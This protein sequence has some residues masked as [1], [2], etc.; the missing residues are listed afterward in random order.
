MAAATCQK[1]TLS[2]EKSTAFKCFLVAV[3][4]NFLKVQ[5]WF[6][7]SRIYFIGAIKNA[8]PPQFLVCRG[9]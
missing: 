8:K 5:I 7:P 4:G 3:A 9:F 1:G 2:K 6:L